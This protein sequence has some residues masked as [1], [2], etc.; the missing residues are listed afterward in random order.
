MRTI[1]IALGVS[2]VLLGLLAGCSGSDN[3]APPAD[4]GRDG[5]TLDAS[6]DTSASDGGPRQDAKLPGDASSDTQAALDGSVTTAMAF[7]DGT[8]GPVISS[9]ESCCNAGDKATQD[10]AFVDGLLH[11]LQSNCDGSLAAGVA[12]G[13]ATFDENA[14]TQC[15]A[16]VQQAIQGAPLCW[17]S[18]FHNQNGRSTFAN[19][20]CNAALVGQ[21]ASSAA[22]RNDY[23]CKDGLTCIGWTNS[24]DGTCQPPPA[25][26]QACGHGKGDGGVQIFE[27]WGFGTHPPCAAGNFCNF[28]QCQAQ[29]T[30]GGACVSSDDECTPGLHCLL[31]KCGAQG[32][33]AVAAPCMAV[34][35]CKDGLYCQPG[36]GGAQGTCAGKRA[37]GT[38]CNA[39]TN[40]ECSGYCNVADG[41]GTGASCAAIC[42]SN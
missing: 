42:G 6:S 7:C 12:G 19:P 11:F 5:T 39:S 32:P 29:A 36:G 10:Y 21:Q 26:S 13:R 37:A 35:D 17:N 25:V 1:V 16:V 18:F 24:S 3:V 41:G 23:E 14:A 2:T 33:N 38:T 22:C 27:D 20:P 34:S 28:G 30:S 15:V 4:A 31:G 8:L 9:F 40:D